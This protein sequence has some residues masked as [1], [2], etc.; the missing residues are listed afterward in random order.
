[1]TAFDK[2]WFDLESVWMLYLYWAMCDNF[3]FDVY[4]YV[5]SKKFHYYAGDRK[6][7]DEKKTMP[8]Q[9][10]KYMF[11]NRQNCIPNPIGNVK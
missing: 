3:L 8:W 9:Y 7:M 1:M 2:D 4:D 11:L 6:K 10:Q 5:N